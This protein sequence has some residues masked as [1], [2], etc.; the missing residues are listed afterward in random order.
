MRYFKTDVLT[1]LGCNIFKNDGDRW[2]AY[3]G[4]EAKWYPIEK[5]PVEYLKDDLRNGFIQLPSP[6]EGP[7]FRP[8]TEAEAFIEIL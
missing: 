3:I 1:I 2:W 5:H 6:P 8:M 7:L 4:P